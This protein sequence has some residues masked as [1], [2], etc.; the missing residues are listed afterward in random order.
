VARHG[1]QRTEAEDAA[2]IEA[3]VGHVRIASGN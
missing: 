2:G 3:F 1:T